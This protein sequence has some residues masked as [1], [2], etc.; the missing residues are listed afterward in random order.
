MQKTKCAAAKCNHSTKPVNQGKV[1]MGKTQRKG[2]SN[3]KVIHLPFHNN[4]PRNGFKL[5]SKEAP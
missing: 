5:G 1:R 4:Y 2:T 3:K